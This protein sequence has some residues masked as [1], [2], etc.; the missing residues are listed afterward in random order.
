MSFGRFLSRT[1]LGLLLILITGFPFAI[2][3]GS[4]WR[5]CLAQEVAPDPGEGISQGIVHQHLSENSITDGGAKSSAIH[6]SFQGASGIMMSNQAAGNINNQ[7]H[8]AII[9]I[10][11]P[12]REAFTG[13]WQESAGNILVTGPSEY[14]TA[15]SGTSFQG[16]RGVAAVNQVAGN[17]NNQVTVIGVA[18]GGTPGV[19]ISSYN[20]ITS[21]IGNQVSSVGNFV[22]EA[23][24][25]DQAFQNFTGICAVSQVVGNLNSTGTSINLSF[26]GQPAVVALST[27]QLA[28]INS[29][30]SHSIQGNF[31][32]KVSLQDNALQGSSGVAAITQVAGNLNQVLGNVSVNVNMR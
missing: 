22:A 27:T 5:V 4:M 1:L 32:A 18:A 25:M 2:C 19:N 3:S 16:A 30:N 17:L 20:M 24:L 7:G 13:T 31:T 26:G 23:K 28:A 14:N 6:D 12:P 8:L 29:Q 21:S 15:V 10:G 9:T 11:A